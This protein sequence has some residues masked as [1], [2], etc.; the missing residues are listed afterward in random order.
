MGLIHNSDMR[1]V[2]L[3]LEFF[4]ELAEFQPEI[5]F[6]ETH[7]IAIVEDILQLQQIPENSWIET[8][9]K[10]LGISILEQMA[11]HQNEMGTKVS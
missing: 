11:N 9:F 8:E 6:L 2:K 10:S 4:V 5:L 7:T 1:I 3:A